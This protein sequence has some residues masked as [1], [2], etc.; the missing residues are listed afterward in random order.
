MNQNDPGNTELI[1]HDYLTRMNEYTILIQYYLNKK[2]L[3]NRRNGK[4][5]WLQNIL[6]IMK[7]QRTS[8]AAVHKVRVYMEEVCG[9]QCCF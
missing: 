2:L 6:S 7:L 1:P 9:N 4:Y 5:Y 3:M 8:V